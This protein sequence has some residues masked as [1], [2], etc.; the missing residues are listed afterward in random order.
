MYKNSEL[1]KELEQGA[2]M[3]FDEFV[4]RTEE[5]TFLLEV[6]FEYTREFRDSREGYWES[7]YELYMSG[8]RGLNLHDITYVVM[9]KIEEGV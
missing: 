9:S 8:Y 2:I 6:E 7:Q 1:K 5:E 3:I 4:G